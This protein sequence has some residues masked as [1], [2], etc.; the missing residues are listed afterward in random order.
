MVSAI[1]GF[2]TPAAR[3]CEGVPAWTT[4]DELFQTYGEPAR[5]HLAMLC[6]GGRFAIKSRQ[7]HGYEPSYEF[8]PPGRALTTEEARAVRW[9]S[10]A[11]ERAS[12]RRL[13]DAWQFRAPPL[14]EYTLPLAD[15]ARAI[16]LTRGAM[17]ALIRDGGCG[18]FQEPCGGGWRVPVPEVERLTLARRAQRKAA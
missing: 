4:E 12:E 1:V 7:P 3:A 18:G 16:G 9:G 14:F 17:Y 6:A 5:L 8:L 11:I 15:A 13:S 2:K 10:L